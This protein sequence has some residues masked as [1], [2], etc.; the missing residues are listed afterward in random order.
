MLYNAIIVLL[1]A[2]GTG[3][4]YALNYEFY[5]YLLTYLSVEPMNIRDEDTIKMLK[6]RKFDRQCN[7]YLKVSKQYDHDTRQ[8]IPL[9]PWLDRSDIRLYDVFTE[10]LGWRKREDL[11][12]QEAAIL[13]YS[14]PNMLGESGTF[15]LQP[16]LHEVFK[17]QQGVEVNR[18]TLRNTYSCR[19][20]PGNGESW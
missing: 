5:T 11:L 8:F 9:I 7:S 20:P 18:H 15:M 2:C 19:R 1:L 17:L 6:A 13:F 12:T 3:L 16:V 4:I 14:Q 10:W